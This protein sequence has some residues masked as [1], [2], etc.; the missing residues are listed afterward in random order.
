VFN[1]TLIKCFRKAYA[2]T[3]AICS[4]HL[5]SHKGRECHQV[6]RSPILDSKVKADPR[7]TVTH[8]PGK[9]QLKAILDNRRY[10]KLNN[11]LTKVL[12]RGIQDNKDSKE[13][14]LDN[15]S[16][17]LASKHHQEAF[18]RPLLTRGRQDLRTRYRTVGSTC[19]TFLL[20]ATAY[21]ENASGAAKPDI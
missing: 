3:T 11:L 10:I 20:E 18:N 7:I 5:G 4:K 8:K 16:R 13:A 21:P 15:S 19:K 2:G 12:N 17:T 14:I 6:S 1:L 9:S